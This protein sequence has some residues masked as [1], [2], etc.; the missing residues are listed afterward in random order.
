MIKRM[1]IALMCCMSIGFMVGGCTPA[2]D[3]KLDDFDINADDDPNAKPDDLN[4]DTS[5]PRLLLRAGEEEALMKN[6]N[7]D[8]RWLKLHNAILDE[9]NVL[10][11]SDIRVVQVGV[12]GNY[13][14]QACDIVRRVLFLAYSYRTTGEEKY[15]AK[16]KEQILSVVG[17][18]NW[19]PY[20]FLDVAE[21]TFAVS[22]GYDWLY[23]NFTEQ[24]RLIIANAIRDKGLITSEVGK[25]DPAYE[26]RWMSLENNWCQ[27]CHSSMAIGAIALATEEP[28]IS[29]RII[30]RSKKHMLIPMKAEYPP[31]GAYPEGIGYWGYGT[32]LNAIFIDALETYLTDQYADTDEMRGVQGFMQT[33]NYYAQLVTPTL[34]TFGFSDNS[35]SLLTPEHIIFWFYEQ[36]KDP[37]LLYYQAKLVDKFTNPE[38]DYKNGRPF[39]DQ[40]VEGSAARHLPLMMIWGAGVGSRP[41]ADMSAGTEPSSLFY[42]SEG[43]NPI[44]VMRSGWET[45]DMYLGFKVGN[46]S[47]SHGH[48]DVGTFQMEWSGARF[49]VDLGSDGYSRVANGVVS[50]ALPMGSQFDMTEGSIRWNN[51][52]RYNNRCH[53]TLTINDAL[54]KL[55]TKSDFI[56]SSS[57][58]NCMYA[59]GDLTPTYGGEVQSFKRAVGMIDRKYAIVEDLLVAKSGKDANVVWNMTSKAKTMSF[60]SSTNIITLTGSD[61]KTSKKIY[62]KVVLENPD[63][64]EG[65]TVTHEPVSVNTAYEDSASGHYYLRIRYKVKAGK[66]QR[67]KCYLLPNGQADTNTEHANLI[68]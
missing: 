61:G 55:E 33:G 6:I 66:T 50:G 24:E 32:A 12:R 19:N 20:H 44:C 28:A 16:A 59:V 22:F 46:P 38:T 54:Q 52:T 15:F 56:E 23:D 5:H 68:K 48:M 35:T 43:K 3:N 13:H 26:L 7:A 65:I 53:N 9:A 4:I 14:S 41:T 31:M 63:A 51:L 42:I 1:F 39:S 40:I 36:T 64:S 30:E 10:C 29:E 67:M 25:D 11:N 18:D 49:A 62:I 8:S 17:M 27:V 21:M 34:N 45:T 2:P 58:E 60:N 57:Q 47:C 37:E